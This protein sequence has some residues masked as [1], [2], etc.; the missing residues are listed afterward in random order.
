MHIE[1]SGHLNLVD[2]EA[3]KDLSPDF[4]TGASSWSMSGGIPTCAVEAACP[5]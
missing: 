2:E 4:V 1:G 5:G 3:M